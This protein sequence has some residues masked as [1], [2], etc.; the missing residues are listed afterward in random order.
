MR[1]LVIYLSSYKKESFLAPFFQTS[2]SR[3]RSDRTTGCGTDHR[4]GHCEQ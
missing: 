2:G 3:F 1:K 4:R